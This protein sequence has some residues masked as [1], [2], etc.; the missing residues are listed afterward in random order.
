MRKIF[1]GIVFVAVLALFMASAMA[2]NGPGHAEAGQGQEEM[3]IADEYCS[4]CHR[5]LQIDRSYIYAHHS[6]EVLD[7]LG[8][9][10][11]HSWLVE[12]PS[13]FRLIPECGLCHTG[14]QRIHHP[15]PGNE[16][17]D[18]H[19]NSADGSLSGSSCSRIALAEHSEIDETSCLDCHS[20]GNQGKK[21]QNDEGANQYQR[22]R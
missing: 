6:D 8:C 13:V 9:M 14:G 15:L 2:G 22:G 5:Q 7:Q 12:T 20:V 11:C 10:D 18:C 16:C 19:S 4:A 17:A 21:N 1:S 3:F